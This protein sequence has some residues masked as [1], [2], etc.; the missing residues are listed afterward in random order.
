METNGMD[1]NPTPKG[2]T[3][4][5]FDRFL[6]ILHPNPERAGEEYVFLWQRLLTFFQSRSCLA[7]DELADETL[8]RVAKK[9][10]GGEEPRS[11]SAYSHGFA[12]NVWLE[13]LKKPGTNRGSLDDIPPTPSLTLDEISRKERQNCF[14]K[15]LR[16]IPVNEAQMLVEYWYHED[17]PNRDIRREMAERLEISPTALRIRICR[18]KSKVDECIKKCLGEK[19][20]KTK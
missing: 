13:H 15:C 17:R 9:I 7:P 16:E 20:K 12:K 6:F 14:E 11:I 1:D 3:K 18:I 2:L 5:E 4:A 8:N 19:I 10:A